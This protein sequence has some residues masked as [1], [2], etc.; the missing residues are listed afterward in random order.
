MY[1]LGGIEQCYVRRGVQVISGELEFHLVRIDKHREAVPDKAAQVPFVAA[2][3]LTPRWC[4]Q[5]IPL[6]L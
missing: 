3:N 5:C 1:I 6:Q 4:K 2:T